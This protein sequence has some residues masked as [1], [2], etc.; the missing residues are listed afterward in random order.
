MAGPQCP[1][2]CALYKRGSGFARTDG[3][4]AN[5]VMLLGEALGEAEVARSTPFVGAAG[6]MLGTV[7]HRLGADRRDFLIANC[8][9]CRPPNNWLENAPWE[10]NALANC[11]P[12]FDET[13]ATHPQIKVIVP[14]G[15]VPLHYLLREKGVGNFHGT[16][17]SIVRRVGDRE[18]N[19]WVVP[20]FHPSYLMR[21]NYNEIQTMRFDLQRALDIAASG[22][23]YREPFAT[24]E[25]PSSTAV[26]E[27]VRA[28]QA[29]LAADPT[30]MLA[31]DI[32]TPQSAALAEDDAEDSESYQIERISFA[33]RED[34]GITMPWSG[35][36]IEAAKELLAADGDVTFWN[37]DRFDVPRLRA[38]GA[39]VTREVD[40]QEAWH[41]LYPDL[42][43]RLGYVAP[44]LTDLPPWKHLNAANPTYYSCVDSI[45]LLRIWHRLISMIRAAGR[46]ESFKSEILECNRR[47]AQ[48]SVNGIAID[49]EARLAMVVEQDEAR[50]R[51]HVEVQAHV[52]IE[53]RDVHPKAG[54]KRPAPDGRCGEGHKITEVC[55]CC[56]TTLG[57]DPAKVPVDFT[58]IEVEDFVVEEG[59]TIVRKFMRYAKVKDFNPGSHQQLLR[60]LKWRGH[61]VPKASKTGKDTVERDKLE[62]L[63]KSSGD[64]VLQLAV[65]A[66]EHQSR[67]VFLKQWEPSDDG[68]LHGVFTNNPATFR[69]ATKN[70]NLQ[71]F[72]RRSAEMAKL[73][74]MVVPGPGYQWLV[75]RDYSGIE[76][77]QVALYAG[78]N[79]YLRLATR[80]V[81]AYFAA[82]QMGNRIDLSMSDSDL[83]LAIAE[84]KKSTARHFLPGMDS[85]IYDAAKRGNHLTNYG[86][87]E[88]ML[89]SQ[90]PE[91]FPTRKHGWVFQQLM[92]SKFPKVYLQWR[93]A[94]VDRAHKDAVL[95]N[96]FGYPRYFW[97]V[98]QPKRGKTKR[99]FTWTLEGRRHFDKD[100]WEWIFANVEK[101]AVFKNVPVPTDRNG[102]RYDWAED[103][104]A[105]IATLPQSSAAI[106]MRRAILRDAA[107]QLLDEGKLFLTIHDELIARARD[108][109]DADK[110]D[111]LLRDAMEYPVREQGDR[112]FYTSAKRG[113]DWSEME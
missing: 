67:A 26:W 17:H 35:I 65:A 106:I 70:P 9:N 52:P 73:R 82:Y 91:L 14:M 21:G 93:N 62:A 54:Y 2:D 32:E 86:G 102:W 107:A 37:G 19:Y 100:D 1:P 85:S 53:L 79:D 22:A 95:V 43:K 39:P 69:F 55:D 97:Y 45:A 29:A 36:Y 87:T 30:L 46:E 75:A 57:W 3:T 48:M 109:A 105:A 6:L 104:K 24:I 51:I 89:N 71:N 78:D 49:N 64:P 47:T 111:E 72:P 112:V 15:N 38:A 12:Y 76:A 63:A 77:I 27:Y 74:C 16:V 31:S 34:E 94:V 8:A 59:R 11:V 28:Y 83:D 60:Y 81:H 108:D 20:T 99:M 7:L 56:A 40:A 92:F 23:Y 103:A 50:E 90:Y 101:A 110:V 113:H 18:V 96:D 84:A 66:S 25:Q 10:Q 88:S 33:F 4:G 80:G 98:K 13:L 58:S 44:F 41:F 42:P 61:K 68:L 5:G